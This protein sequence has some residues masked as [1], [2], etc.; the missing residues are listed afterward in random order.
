[1]IVLDGLHPHAHQEPS[2]AL[3][4]GIAVDQ[5]PEA[6]AVAGLL[7]VGQLVHQDV[8]AHKSRHLGYAVGNA[9]RAPGWRA[10]SSAL[11][12][13]GHPADRGPLELAVKVKPVEFSRPA[14]ERTVVQLGLA[15]AVGQLFSEIVDDRRQFGVAQVGGCEDLENSVDDASLDRF[16]AFFAANDLGLH[17]GHYSILVMFLQPPRPWNLGRAAALTFLGG[18]GILQGSAECRRTVDQLKWFGFWNKGREREDDP[19]PDGDGKETRALDGEARRTAKPQVEDEAARR[20]RVEAEALLAARLR[21]L[22]ES[23]DEPTVDDRLISYAEYQLYVDERRAAGEARQPDHWLGLRFPWEEG[24]APV[25]GVRYQDAL[26]FCQWLTGRDR[27]GRRYRLPYAEE[28]DRSALPRGV[29]LEVPPG[30]GYWVTTASGE[31]MLARAS[32][33]ECT[34]RGA[35]VA[36]WLDRDLAAGRDLYVESALAQGRDLAGKMGLD[37]DLDRAEARELA[38]ALAEAL[39]RVLDRARENDRRLVEALEE[40]LD[41]ASRIDYALD[42]GGA[43]DLGGVLEY[44]QQIDRALAVAHYRTNAIPRA[45]SLSRATSRAID[46]VRALNASV[47]RAGVSDVLRILL[48]T[49]S[50]TSAVDR[51]HMLAQNVVRDF[52]PATGLASD[53]QFAHTLSRVREVDLA[54]MLL[55]ACD[56]SRSFDLD[57]LVAGDSPLGQNRRRDALARQDVLAHELSRVHNILHDPDLDHAGAHALDRVRAR[58]YE[59]TLVRDLDLVRVMSRCAELARVQACAHAGH[60][61]EV[62]AALELSEALDLL[63]GRSFWDGAVTDWRELSRSLR[64][65]IRFGALARVIEL[66]ALLQAPDGWIEPSLE[67]RAPSEARRGRLEA[68]RDAALDVYIQLGILEDRIEG[69]L[70]A[71]E[72]VRVVRES[73]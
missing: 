44:V 16:P 12:L 18:C 19:D 68:Q 65:F 21:R 38:G 14:F 23:G 36:A 31:G 3:G 27:S 54:M 57:R 32:T 73:G 8:V 48:L 67:A 11:G 10:A 25:V 34:L 1:L 66:G 15:G 33:R 39:D 45:R 62:V 64:Q 5:F 58:D 43:R 13:V 46:Q 40:A 4:L 59:Q 69:H 35:D 56:V 47:A 63:A 41:G 17:A 70:P 53:L 26:A 49:G 71:W 60:R 52:E 37:P 30:G 50:R 20:R 29:R 42:G 6:G 24:T 9:D 22:A 51:A 2:G 28:P 61:R 55:R 7:Q 72:G